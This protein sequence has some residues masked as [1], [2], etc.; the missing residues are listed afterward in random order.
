[1]PAPVYERA[2]GRLY[3]LSSTSQSGVAGYWSGYLTSAGAGFGD[4]ATLAQVWAD[5][6]GVYLF[7]AETPTDPAAFAAALI[8]IL[9]QLSPQGWLRFAWIANPNEAASAWQVLGLDATPVGAASGPWRVVR[10]MVQSLSDYALS[11]LGGTTLDL[12]TAADAEGVTLTG[13]LAFVAPGAVRS[14]EHT[15]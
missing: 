11:V 2:T 9:P 15:S 7:L 13:A 3:A 5:R 1:M 14:E 10:D 8:A 4:Q 6:G 12:T